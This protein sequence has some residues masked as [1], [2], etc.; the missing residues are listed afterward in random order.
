MRY[1]A[2]VL[3]KND[4]IIME[5]YITNPRHIEVQIIADK[6]GNIVCLGDR[7]CSIQR[8]HQKIIEEAPS[9][10]INEN[11]RKQMYNTSIKIAKKCKYYS[12][13]TLEFIVDEKQQFYFMEMNTRLQ[14]EHG[15]T[16]YITGLDLVELMIK[17]EEGKKLPFS[18]TDIKI[19]G[20]AIECRIC[21][22]RPSKNFIPS[23][24][25]ITHYIEPEKNSNVR[26]D[27]GVQLGDKITYYFDSMLAKLIV[28]GNTRT[29]A[30]ELMKL[31]LSEYEIDGIDTNISFLE[32][33]IRKQDFILGNLTTNFI[34]THY[35]D[36]FNNQNINNEA[37][38]NFICSAIILYLLNQKEH[39]TSTPSDDISYITRDTSFSKLYVILNDKSFFIEIENFD[40]K[41]LSISYNK[42]SITVGYS[43]FL[44]KLQLID[45]ISNK[46]F[47]VKI[48]KLHETRMRLQSAGIEIY[49]EI[50][51]QEIYEYIKYMP[52]INITDNK[53]KFLFSHITG[54]VSNI[55]VNINDIVDIDS[56][57]LAIDA[58]KMTNNIV[59][60][61]KAKIKNIFV[62]VG[63]KV[64]ENDK[65]IE[66]DY[67]C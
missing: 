7:E 15:I 41:K 24:G 20:H 27:T 51:T 11:T 62:K 63:D 32:N 65:L 46:V 40:E 42:Q 4:D 23:L 50:Y 56:D 45:S 59:S 8:K 33:I 52:T 18:Q 1:E 57:L 14:V 48:Q 64:K 31:K 21:A 39:F 67:H 60:E 53:P 19:Q 3:F 34:A 55:K 37:T 5:K 66:F 28:Y 22:E 38:K 10:F 30:I 2:K 43:Y 47:F 58:M 61:H 26:I 12:V 6:Y 36:G 49:C 54:I 25:K 29:D 13:G 9:I 35:P 44:N 17:I 16:E